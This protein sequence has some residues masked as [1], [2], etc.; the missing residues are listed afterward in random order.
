M[1]SPRLTVEPALLSAAVKPLLSKNGSFILFYS[2]P[3]LGMRISRLLLDECGKQNM[4]GELVKAEEAFFQNTTGAGLWDSNDIEITLQKEGFS[5]NVRI[6][7]QKEERL[8][9]E[10]DIDAWFNTEQSRW[11]MFMSQNL[12]KTNFSELEETIRQRIEKG[13]V[14]WTWQSVCFRANI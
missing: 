2:P 14:L 4:T 1:R 7:E 5:V 12:K 6:V 3:R 13:P 11:G 10:K 8:I 9:T